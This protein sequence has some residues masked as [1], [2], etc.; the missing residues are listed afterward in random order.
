MYLQCDLIPDPCTFSCV[1]HTLTHAHTV[2]VQLLVTRRSSD[3]SRLLRLLGRNNM[4]PLLVGDANVSSSETR[5]RICCSFVFPASHESSLRGAGVLPSK[6]LPSYS[7]ASVLGVERLLLPGRAG[8]LRWGISACRSADVSSTFA[9][10]RNLHSLSPVAASDGATFL[11][12]T[13][14]RS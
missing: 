6:E 13:S 10:I 2:S 8:A 14:C 12:D 1:L 5:R 7:S 11:R 9:P 3:T 4:R